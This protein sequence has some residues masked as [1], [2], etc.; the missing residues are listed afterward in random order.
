MN[1][2]D[3]VIGKIADDTTNATLAA[4]IAGVFGNIGDKEA[5]EF[6]IKQLLPERLKDQYCFKTEKSLECLRFIEGEKI[7]LNR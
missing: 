1:K 4:Y 5:D 3:V 7:W 6:C 2:Y